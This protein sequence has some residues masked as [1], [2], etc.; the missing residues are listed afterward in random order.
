MLDHL[1]LGS[2]THTQL[3][4]IQQVRVY[5]MMNRRVLD[6]NS[7]NFCWLNC[8]VSEVDLI[9]VSGLFLGLICWVMNYLEILSVWCGIHGSFGD[10]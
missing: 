5:G 4:S 7:L 6:E 8:S 3:F 2:F 1:V 9:H 10:V